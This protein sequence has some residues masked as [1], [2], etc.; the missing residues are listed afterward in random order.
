MD[1]GPA[2]LLRGKAGQNRH[3][4]PHHMHGKLGGFREWLWCW[5]AEEAVSI[6]IVNNFNL[7]ATTHESVRKPTYILSVT[8]EIMWWVEGSDHR[9]VQRPRHVDRRWSPVHDPPGHDASHKPS[10]FIFGACIWK[11]SGR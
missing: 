5:A 4:A 1:N 2:Q 9:D 7:M 3:W 8:A 6:R 11:T 10:D